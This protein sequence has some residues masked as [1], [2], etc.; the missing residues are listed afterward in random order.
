MYY[1]LPPGPINNPGKPALLAA[2]YPD[3]NNYLYFV[4]DGNGGHKFSKTYSE[5]LRNVREYRRWLR[6]QENK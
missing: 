2:L 3:N 6:A 1:G 5:H 4:A